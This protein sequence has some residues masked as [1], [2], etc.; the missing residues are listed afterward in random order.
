MVG[1]KSA[2]LNN[3]THITPTT[4]VPHHPPTS[5]KHKTLTRPQLLT[6]SQARQMFQTQGLRYIGASSP[7]YWIGVE[8]PLVLLSCSAAFRPTNERS[9]IV[10]CNT[11]AFPLHVHPTQL[12]YRAS[13]TGT[14]N[15]E[16]WYSC[17]PVV[18]STRLI[19]SLTGSCQRHPPNQAHSNTQ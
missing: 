14:A 16:M 8:C 13:S 3:I 4:I 15:A 11:A 12:D 18:T 10:G 7:Y 17:C 2:L 9:V 1:P 5:M 6:P 19:P